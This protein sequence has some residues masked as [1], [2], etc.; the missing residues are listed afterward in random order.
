ML[1][2]AVAILIIKVI[3]SNLG[4]TPQ[5]KL[6][7]QSRGRNDSSTFFELKMYTNKTIFV[8]KVGRNELFF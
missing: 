8:E 6:S 2:I 7:E 1:D 3:V 5:N 4:N